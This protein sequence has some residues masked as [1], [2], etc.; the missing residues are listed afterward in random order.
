MGNNINRALRWGPM[1]EK[2]LDEIRKALTLKDKFIID[3]DLIINN[4]T[5]TFL[6]NLPKKSKSKMTKKE[7]VYVGIHLR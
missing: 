1:M 4:I 5:Q 6:S 3:A 7:R 2:H